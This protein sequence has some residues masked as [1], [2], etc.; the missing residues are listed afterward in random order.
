[1]WFGKSK[2]NI[3]HVQLFMTEVPI[4]PGFS[5]SHLSP[6]VISEARQD[7]LVVL[8]TDQPVSS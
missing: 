8:R 7:L 5:Y 4:N 3:I 2:N 6:W 1:M